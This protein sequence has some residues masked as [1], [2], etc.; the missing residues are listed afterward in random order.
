[1]TNG[2][3]SVAGVVQ[4]NKKRVCV[5]LQKETVCLIKSKSGLQFLT[6]KSTPQ[7]NNM[8]TDMF[9]NPMSCFLINP[10]A[11]IFLLTR[12]PSCKNATGNPPGLHRN[13]MSRAPDHGT[14]K[15][16]VLSPVRAVELRFCLK[17]T[18]KKISITISQVHLMYDLFNL[19]AYILD[20]FN[21]VNVGK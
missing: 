2:N 11:G 16:S 12:H 10:P 5:A 17:N 9:K 7:K 19:F 14:Q 4:K 6:K 8:E 18:I 21:Q 13:G 15:S 3:E 20:S 1:M